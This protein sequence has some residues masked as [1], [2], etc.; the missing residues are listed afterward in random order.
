MKNKYKILIDIILDKLN[1]M[2]LTYDN[3]EVLS[4]F[5]EIFIKNNRNKK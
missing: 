3:N 1:I 2:N 5:G 4:L